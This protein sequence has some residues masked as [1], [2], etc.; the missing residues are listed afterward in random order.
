V[1]PDIEREL[2]GQLLTSDARATQSVVAELGLKPEHFVFDRD[3]ATFTALLALVDRGVDFPDALL[4]AEELN[5]D[6]STRNYL[7]EMAQTVNNPYANPIPFAEK[8]IRRAEWRR[9]DR[10]SGLLAEAV[11]EGDEVKLAE[12]REQITSDQ[13]HTRS[14]LTP[15]NLRS[16]LDQIMEG[17]AEKEFPFPFRKFND[18]TAGGLG[19][20]EHH[21]IAGHSSHGKSLWL[22]Q[23]LRHWGG[24]FRV[25]LYTNEMNADSRLVR[26]VNTE[27]GVSFTA[28][29]SGRLNDQQKERIRTIARMNLVFGITDATGWTAREISN[30]IR[31]NRWDVAGVDMLHNVAPEASES[32]QEQTLTN[33]SRI[34]TDT[35]RQANCLVVS[36]SHLNEKRTFSAEKPRPTLG[37]VRGSG[38]IKNSAD[39]VAFVWRKQDLE[40]GLPEPEGEI[41]LAKVR[42]GVPGWIDV[43]L[44]AQKLEFVEL[45]RVHS[46]WRAAA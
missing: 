31:L 25:H 30:D 46:N 3:Q 16:R 11:T 34:L 33:A 36:V 26:Q 18:L 21:A 24:I 23:L 29:L 37:D 13:A 42:N 45:D 2:L 17:A 32:S 10:A 4:V 6:E 22:D 5:A 9:L 14:T 27:E 39:S 40:R 43:R 28:I 41:T 15:D 38:M 35:C 20:K 8:V 44:E 1:I 12:A 7:I 19:R